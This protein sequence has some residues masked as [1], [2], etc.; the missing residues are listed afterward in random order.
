MNCPLKCK[1]PDCRTCFIFGK[2][3]SCDYPFYEN[4][5]CE[6]VDRLIQ[7]KEV[8]ELEVG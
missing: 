7:L 5:E 3:G 1:N 4:K 8:K 6:V 2:E